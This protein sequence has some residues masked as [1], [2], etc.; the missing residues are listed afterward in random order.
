MTHAG[1]P[2][3]TQDTSDFDGRPEVERAN[4]AAVAAGEKIEEKQFVDYFA[5]PLPQRWY[6]P[7]G[8]QYFEFQELREGGKSAYEKLTNKDIRVQRSTGDARLSVDPAIQR[9]SLIRLSV[10]DVYL[11]QK[12]SGGQPQPMPFNKER[13]GK[14]WENL[15]TFFPAALIDKLHREIVDINAWL[16]ADDDVDALKEERERLDERIAKA[17]EE[18]AKKAL[19]VEQAA[20]F[21]KGN[22]IANPHPALLIYGR[23]EAMKWSIPYTPGGLED[24]SVMLLRCFDV[25]N[26]VKAEHE[27]QEQK[28][29]EQESKSKRPNPRGGSRPTGRRKK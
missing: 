16:A 20:D 27:R 17:E 8:V 10:T 11:L 1:I 9:Q 23:L 15:F 29:R 5:A 21:V 18:Q 2:T 3:A 4:A 24:Q 26:R 25:I 14:F 12:D 28:K 7:D 22:R 6:L 19:L 13:P